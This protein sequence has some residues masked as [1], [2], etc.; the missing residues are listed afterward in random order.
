MKELIQNKLILIFTVVLCTIAIIVIAIVHHF[1]VTKSMD[2]DT[3]KSQVSNSIQLESILNISNPYEVLKKIKEISTSRKFNASEEKRIQEKTRDAYSK[4]IYSASSKIR[5]GDVE[6]ATIVVTQLEEFFPNNPRVKNLRF[7]VTNLIPYIGTVEHIFFH[8]LIVYPERA[9]P[10]SGRYT[11]QDRYMVTVYE[12]KKVM[13]ELYKNNYILIDITTMFDITNH[14]DK[15]I[16]KVSPRTLYL[17]KGK[18]PLILSVDDINYYEYMIRDGQN[19][20]LILDKDGN[21]ATYSKDMQ[22]KEVIS[23]DNEIMTI[24]DSFVDTHPDFSYNNA[25][26]VLGV[27]GYQGVLGW[28]VNDRPS[29]IANYVE[30]A[31]GLKRVIAKLKSNGWTFASH[32]QGHRNTPEATLDTIREDTDRWDQ[33]VRPF[34]GSTPIYIYPFG[35]SI[36]VTDEKFKDLQKH[37]FAVFCTVEQNPILKWGD[38]Y[39]IQSRRNIDGIAFNGHWLD[40]LFNVDMVI[41]PIR[42]NVTRRQ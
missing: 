3:Q 5:S 37:G 13:E 15:S 12:F 1:T 8:P 6:N 31:A 9:F 27:T 33:I 18:K 39:I 34:V 20:K 42:P 10:K 26:G 25:K 38:N 21:L 14:Q 35:A 40:K 17:P 32:S 36:P 4:L 29:R 16:A 11:G 24:L 19:F 28:R 23:H 22:G 41:D 30:E 2:P 7:S